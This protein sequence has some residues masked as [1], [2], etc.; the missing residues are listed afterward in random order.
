M[1]GEVWESP[2]S[3][4]GPWGACES[5]VG[6]RELSSCVVNVK[7]EKINI[8]EFLPCARICARMAI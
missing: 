4:S 5:G 8:S 6:D 2:D 3:V 1:G 7:G